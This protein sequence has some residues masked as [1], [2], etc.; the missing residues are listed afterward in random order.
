MSAAVKPSILA[1]LRDIQANK[2]PSIELQGKGKDDI[3][4]IDTGASYQ[5]PLPKGAIPRFY[6]PRSQSTLAKACR[7]EARLRMLKDSKKQLPSQEDQRTTFFHLERSAPHDG[8]AGLI[9][10][11]A[12]KTLQAK[13]PPSCKKFFSG[14]SFLLF[15][16][17]EAGRV[18]I[19]LVQQYVTRRIALSYTHHELAAYGSTSNG[20][21][22]RKDLEDYVYT[23]LPSL[24]QV[25]ARLEESLQP[26]YIT[27]VARRFFF[28]LPHPQGSV[29][30]E[31]VLTSPMLTELLAL[32]VKPCRN[33]CDPALLPSR[34]MQICT[35]LPHPNAP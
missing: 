21:L 17:D 16:R 7:K 12:F 13:V 10:Y 32:K 2:K 8:D 19:P 18:P 9:T 26:Y 11:D 15:Q 1:V 35:P 25:A 27:A 23:L 31:D 4:L 24:R 33:H 29:A 34:S 5:S 3:P 28:Y 20:R 22:T 6:V 30:V 14:S